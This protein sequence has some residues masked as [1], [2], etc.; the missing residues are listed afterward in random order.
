MRPP[1]RETGNNFILVLRGSDNVYL[2]PYQFLLWEVFG[3]FKRCVFFQAAAV[4]S[5]TDQP[6]QKDAAATGTS[7][8]IK[9][10]SQQQ[11]DN[12]DHRSNRM[13]SENTSGMAT[14]GRGGPEPAQVTFQEPLESRSLRVLLNICYIC[15]FSK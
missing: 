4:Q 10:Q 1:N 12:S 9:R 2:A 14:S 7:S 3:N 15:C 13:T 8:A 6:Q 11:N 5:S